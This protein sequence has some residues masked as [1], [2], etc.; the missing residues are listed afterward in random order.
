MLRGISSP[1]PWNLLKTRKH[2]C[3]YYGNGRN[4]QVAVSQVGGNGNGKG[5]KG[6][7]RA[8]Q[9]GCSSY[10][11]LRSCCWR[12]N[13]EGSVLGSG[14]VWTREGCAQ[15]L[16]PLSIIGKVQAHSRLER[17]IWSFAQVIRSN[18]KILYSTLHFKLGLIEQF[19]PR[20]VPCPCLCLLLGSIAC[21]CAR[22][23]IL[24]RNDL[25]CRWQLSASASASWWRCALMFSISCQ[26]CQIIRGT[27]GPAIDF[28]LRARKSIPRGSTTSKFLVKASPPAHNSAN[29]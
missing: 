10:R 22:R 12:W 28:H 20:N 1:C 13:L 4:P 15:H 9:G 5:G 23:A 7:G 24:G 25:I 6:K 27:Q 2:Q 16:I 21:A 26:A 8:R 18:I 3:Q 14:E 11:D 19:G 29:L 17:E